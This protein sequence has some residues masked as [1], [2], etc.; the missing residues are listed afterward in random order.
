MSEKLVAYDSAQIEQVI[1]LLRGQKVILDRDLAALYGVA[2]GSLNRAVKRNLDRFPSDFMIQLTAE[3]AEASRCQIGTLKRGQN[4]KYLPCAFTEQGV[5][6][7]SSVLR[8]PQAVQVNIA[9]MHGF[10]S[11]PET[12]RRQKSKSPIITLSPNMPPCYPSGVDL[13]IN[14]WLDHL[15]LHL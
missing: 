6:M 5:A 8:S 12:D 15:S 9:I 14:L 3:E 10:C 4:I 13:C 2:T 7:L 11:L 1:L